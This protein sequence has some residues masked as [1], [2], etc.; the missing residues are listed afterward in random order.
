MAPFL[1][2]PPPVYMLIRL[3]VGLL[4]LLAFLNCIGFLGAYGGY[5]GQ[6]M[7]PPYHR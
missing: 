4:I 6:P 3:L 1:V 2:L 7:F 5:E